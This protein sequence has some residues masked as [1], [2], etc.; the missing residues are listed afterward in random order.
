MLTLHKAVFTCA[1]FERA[2]TA[3][4]CLEKTGVTQLCLSRHSWM[5]S[6]EQLS[7]SYKTEHKGKFVDVTS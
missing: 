3:E 5:A 2:S 6:F 1:D 7:V 4:S